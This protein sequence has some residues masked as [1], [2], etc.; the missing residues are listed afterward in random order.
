[1]L[2]AVQVSMFGSYLPPVFVTPPP[3]IPP[4]M[5]ISVPVHTPVGMARFS[6]A[7]TALV[8]VQL[9]F[10]GL[11]FPPMLVTLYPPQAIISVPVHTVV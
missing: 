8:A 11:Y 7:L 1:M 9:S 6:G 2:V 10:V 3:E 4:Q 5:I